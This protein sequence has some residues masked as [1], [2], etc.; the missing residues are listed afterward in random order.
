[1]ATII[2]LETKLNKLLQRKS[3][4]H[5]YYD[6]EMHPCQIIIQLDVMGYDFT[7]EQFDKFILCGIYRKSMGFIA[8]EYS[9]GKNYKYAITIMFS[10]FTPSESQFKLLFDCYR[11][12]YTDS[13][14]WA[15]VLVNR[16]YNFSTENIRK[17]ELLRYDTKKLYKNK[18][19]TLS[20]LETMLTNIHSRDMAI[21]ETII[22][23]NKIEPS[24]KCMRNAIASL[25]FT[26]G[27]RYSLEEDTKFIEMLLKY[28]CEPNEECVKLLLEKITEMKIFM[29]LMMKVQPTLN[30]LKY[31][32][33]KDTS[34]YH[35]E[36]KYNNS[37][38]ITYL[39]TKGVKPNTECLNA[40]MSKILLY[41]QE[42][43][44][45]VDNIKKDYIHN[46]KF[47][48]Y[49]FL[50]YNGAKPDKRTLNLACR[51]SVTYVFEDITQNHKI[52]PDKL[53]LDVAT[54]FSSWEM[55]EKILNYKILP[56]RETFIQCLNGVTNLL[57]AKI[58][59]LIEHGL[60]ITLELIELALLKKCHIN[61]LDRFD[62][63]YDNTLYY[64]CYKCDQ[65][66]IEYI[67][68][69]REHIGEEIV[70]FRMMCKCTKLP[71]E[72]FKTY[73]KKNNI[74]P[75]RYCLENLCT[76]NPRVARYMINTLKCE[77]TIGCLYQQTYNAYKCLH[78]D[79]LDILYKKY[80]FD[81]KIMT[82]PYNNIYINK[83]IQTD[84]DNTGIDEESE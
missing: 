66:P 71:L 36:W 28:K 55:M 31:V 12:K 52:C 49:K 34:G 7:Q 18:P 11:G 53:C 69:F 45:N 42:K 4:F 51:N 72:Y 80:N 37:N 13:F 8:Y 21:I 81:S 40:I 83:L 64:I 6:D 48:L 9:K 76:Y 57:D 2:E 32:C 60:L 65:W 30:L 23:K 26:N 19:V 16:N 63:P 43:I 77:P 84:G 68:K 50:V 54:K 1:M 47:S 38:Q 5:S 27:W 61:D 3:S 35:L 10:K 62:I 74:R 59:L 14:L 20:K 56:D 75:D 82:K 67:E 33:N 78:R 46:N 44:Y 22:E 24:T 79:I 29:M 39:I 58:K 41:E 17:L 70:E 73:I 25:G 15:D